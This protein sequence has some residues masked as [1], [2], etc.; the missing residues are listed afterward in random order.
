LLGEG[1]LESAGAY[2][3]SQK[4]LILRWVNAFNARNLEGLLACLHPEVDFHPLKLVGLDRSYRGH[5]GVRRWFDRLG[6]L[7]YKH[8]IDLGEVRDSRQ[9]QLLAIGSVRVRK[10]G[11]ITPF[12]ATHTIKDE[13]IAIARHYPH[14]A[15]SVE[16]VS[17]LSRMATP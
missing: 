6:E 7:R 17:L 13:L 2:A 15:D 5:D 14:E 16:R 12:C 9:G 4:A 10:Y 8:L 3:L 1:V 11:V